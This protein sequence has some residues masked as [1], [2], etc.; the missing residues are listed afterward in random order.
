MTRENYVKQRIRQKGCSLKAFAK[1]IQMP[2]TTLLSILKNGLGGS[3]VDNVVKICQGLHISVE[4][5]Q[6]VLDASC[7]E[8]VYLSIHETL[9]IS[10]YRK[11][12][13]LQTAVDILLD[14]QE[15]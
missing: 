2:Y 15:K 7:P 6:S 5:L 3:A 1:E 8:P 12:T 11:K 4:Q 10:Q 14:V 9:V 13:D